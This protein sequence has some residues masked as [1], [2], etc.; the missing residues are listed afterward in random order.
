MPTVSSTSMPRT[1]SGGKPRV[2]VRRFR[3]QTLRPRSARTMS[4][5]SPFRSTPARPAHRS[6]I[7]GHPSGGCRHPA[8][9]SQA[10]SSSTAARVV[11]AARQRPSLRSVCPAASRILRGSNWFAV[12]PFTI[13]QDP[14]FNGK[15][16]DQFIVTAALLN[17]NQFGIDPEMDVENGGRPSVPR[18]RAGILYRADHCL[19]G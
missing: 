8:A 6:L 17:G 14:E 15:S 5:T 11:S 12:G 18:V 19:T 13:V 9:R 3:A 7:Y 1:R 10:R 4:C 16:Q 2:R